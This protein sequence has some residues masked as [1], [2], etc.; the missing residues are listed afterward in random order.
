MNS[1]TGLFKGITYAARGLS[2][3]T[4]KGIRPFVVVPLLINI[5]L[6]SA[7]IWLAS[8]QID[9]W[10]E[11]LLPSWLSWLEWLLWPVFA[12][13]IFFAV[14]YTFSI[15]ANLIAAPFNAILAERVETHLRGLPIP[16]FQGYKTLPAIIVRTFRSEAS[17][18]L[19]ML[20]WLI[21]LLILTVIPGLNMLSPFAWTLFG[22]W[23]LAIE[24]ADYPMGNHELYFKDELQA[25]KKHRGHALGFGWALSLLTLIPVLNFLAMPVGVAGGTALWVDKLAND[26]R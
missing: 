4:H 26:Y 18:L 3:I 8:H 12:V 14:F 22:A 21:A 23:M 24:Y 17:K 9:S 25:L 1:I 5:L 10:M 6:F 19:Y 13:I 11:R 20:K 15:L 16:P 7:G 2:L